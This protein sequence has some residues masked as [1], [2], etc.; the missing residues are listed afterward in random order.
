MSDRLTCTVTGVFPE[1]NQAHAEALGGLSLAV[2]RRTPGINLDELR[3]GDRLVCEVE[4]HPTAV[5]HARVDVSEGS[6][7]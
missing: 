6:S 1:Y 3:P 2:N 7:Q 5:L 4:W